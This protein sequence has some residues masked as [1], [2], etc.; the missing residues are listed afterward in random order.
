MDLVILYVGLHKRIEY[1]ESE[2]HEE[3]YEFEGIIKT[4]D[5][6]YLIECINPH[7]PDANKSRD[8]NGVAIATVNA[9]I[10]FFA[11]C[12]GTWYFIELRKSYQPPNLIKWYVTHQSRMVAISKSLAA[13][14]EPLGTGEPVAMSKLK[15][16]GE[17]P[18]SATAVDDDSVSDA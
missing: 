6:K 16:L 5:G 13:M 2:E 11:G 18:T 3:K 14:A 17:G 10:I 15:G 1:T 7:D 9:L 4:W 12:W 8:A